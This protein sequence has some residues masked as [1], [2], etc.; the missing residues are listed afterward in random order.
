MG[1]D[2]NPYHPTDNV[3]L[4]LRNVH[5][6]EEIHHVLRWSSIRSVT[7]TRTRG[8]ARCTESDTG[9]AI[10]HGTIWLCV[11]K[12]AGGKGPKESCP[13]TSHCSVGQRAAASELLATEQF[14]QGH[15][16][17][18]DTC[19]WFYSGKLKFLFVDMLLQR[20]YVQNTVLCIV[21]KRNKDFPG[22]VH[23]CFP[24]CNFQRVS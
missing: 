24:S 23:L 13:G 15:L 6:G 16:R 8:S 21:I 19:K 11:A 18:I 20:L 14:A 3:H 7:S 2:T 9:N 4:G 12:S 22:G 10:R 5:Y 17:S 1:A